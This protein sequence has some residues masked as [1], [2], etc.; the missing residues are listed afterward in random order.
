MH[1]G[2]D[3]VYGLASSMSDTGPVFTL[4][5]MDF[6]KKF[7]NEFHENKTKPLAADSRLQTEGRK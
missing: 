2:A 6:H 3:F 4:T 1:D 7:N 5:R